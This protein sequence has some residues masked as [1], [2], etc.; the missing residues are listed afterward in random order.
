[1]PLE[2]QYRERLRTI[3]EA[4]GLLDSSE[5]TSPKRHLTAA[6]AHA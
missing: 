6:G 2:E 1:M 4:G 3:L 5:A